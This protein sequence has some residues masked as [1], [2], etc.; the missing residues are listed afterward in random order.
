MTR[1]NY[2]L[3]LTGKYCSPF[4]KIRKQFAFQNALTPLKPSLVNN[5]SSRNLRL[6]RRIPVFSPLPRFCYPVYL[7]QLQL[8]KNA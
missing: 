4:K 7:P 8:R 2:L 1:T 5:I 3:M 6:W